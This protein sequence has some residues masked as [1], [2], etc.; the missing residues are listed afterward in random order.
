MKNSSKNLKNYYFDSFSTQLL[1]NYD[2][3]CQNRYFKSITKIKSFSTPIMW[4]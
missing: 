4:L 2:P 3:K 1:L